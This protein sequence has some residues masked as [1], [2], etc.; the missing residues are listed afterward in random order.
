VSAPRGVPS[1]SSW[2]VRRMPMEARGRGRI[3]GVA[4]C[5][6]KEKEGEEGSASKDKGRRWVDHMGYVLVYW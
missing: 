3:A 4:E 5:R 1:S 6:T 2:L